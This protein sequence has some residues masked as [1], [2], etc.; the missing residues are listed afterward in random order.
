[1]KAKGSSNPRVR[2][3][4][5]MDIYCTSWFLNIRSFLRASFFHACSEWFIVCSTLMCL[6]HYFSLCLNSLQQLTYV[7]TC[8]QYFDLTTISLVKPVWP[9]AGFTGSVWHQLLEGTMGLGG[10]DQLILTSFF[11]AWVTARDPPT[12]PTASILRGTNLA[13]NYKLIGNPHQRKK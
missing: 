9:G 6:G 13:F 10:A 5:F 4:I 12:P 3:R 11:V 2:M 1:M 7:R 8:H